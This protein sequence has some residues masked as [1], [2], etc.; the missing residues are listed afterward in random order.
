MIRALAMTASPGNHTEM[1]TSDRRTPDINLLYADPPWRYG[2]P[3]MRASAQQMYPTLSLDEIK[4]FPL[5]SLAD[6]AFLLMWRVKDLQREAVDVMDAWGFTLRDEIVWVKT[7]K[8]GVKLQIGVGYAIR[9]AHE[10]CLVGVRGKPRI[11][12]HSIPSVIYEKKRRHSQK[13]LQ[14]YGV[15][16]RMCPTGPWFELFARRAWPNWRV[17]GNQAPRGL[18]AHC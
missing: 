5:P 2:A 15:A 13:P 8:P 3:S 7:D 4:N 14:M 11:A 12:D 18:L 1:S 9:P 16:E 10:I 6:D 17:A